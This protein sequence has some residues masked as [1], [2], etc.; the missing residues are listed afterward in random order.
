LD[1]VLADAVVVVLDELLGDRRAAGEVTAAAHHVVVG[2]AQDALG[3]DAALGPEAAVL[4][5]QHRVL[6]VRRDL[7]EVQ[8][9]P[10][11]QADR[12][13]RGRAVV[14]VHDRVL[15][16]GVG[17]RGR[18]HRAVG[19]VEVNADHREDEDAERG[20]GDGERLLP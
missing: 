9:V 10:V 6:Q 19:K 12:A 20:P 8:V 13:D 17:D 14:V 7:V 1:S 18:D 11:E 2:R 16:V 5:G 3:R 4:R 15:V